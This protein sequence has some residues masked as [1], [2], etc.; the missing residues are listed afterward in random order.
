LF[1][2]VAVKVPRQVSMSTVTS[3][4]PLAVSPSA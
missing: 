1:M 3:N 2:R 4:L